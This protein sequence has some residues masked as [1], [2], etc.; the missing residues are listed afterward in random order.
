MLIVIK[1]RLGNAQ[2][3]Q[4]GEVWRT[5]KKDGEDWPEVIFRF[6]YRARES[7]KQMHVIP[8]T[9]SRSSSP[10]ENEE[11]DDTPCVD[12]FTPAQRREFQALCAKFA[13]QNKS[14]SPAVHGSAG[15]RKFKAQ[16]IKIEPTEKRGSCG[17]G[18]RVAKRAKGKQAPVHIDL[19][20]GSESENESE[21]ESENEM[22]VT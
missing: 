15:K 17:G 21:D 12:E 18:D 7:L 22:F 1:H 9:P 10:E 2:K 11:D 20:G 14:S 16:K 3:T 8:R 5:E 6:I 19:T 4:R 13:Q